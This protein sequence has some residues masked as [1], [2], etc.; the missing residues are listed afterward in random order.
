[1]RL[2]TILRSNFFL[3]FYAGRLLDLLSIILSGQPYKALGAPTTLAQGNIAAITRDISASQASQHL[4][5]SLLPYLMF[6]PD[7]K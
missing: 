3:T 2:V 6:V 1:M 4:Y 7:T 5:L